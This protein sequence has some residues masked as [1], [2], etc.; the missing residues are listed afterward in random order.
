MKTVDL[1]PSISN[2]R[3]ASSL[4]ALVFILLT[5]AG[6]VGSRTADLSQSARITDDIEAAFG[7]DGDM[8]RAHNWAAYEERAFPTR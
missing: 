6:C 1:L 7:A 3:G 2:R 4:V 5:L 8:S